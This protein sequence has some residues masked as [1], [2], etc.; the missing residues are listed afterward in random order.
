MSISLYESWHSKYMNV[1]TW[2]SIVLSIILFGTCPLNTIT[3]H[4]RGDIF[5]QNCFV[6]LCKV[7]NAVCKSSDQMCGL[8]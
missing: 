3:S 6:V 2:D 7:Y 1:F 8:D 4:L 5:I